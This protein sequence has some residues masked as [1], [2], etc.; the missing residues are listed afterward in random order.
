MLS[1]NHVPPLSLRSEIT[2]LV[3]TVVWLLVYQA[4]LRGLFLYTHYD[5][6][7]TI[8]SAVLLN[9]F[10]KGFRFDLI[11]TA[12]AVMPMVFTLLFQRRAAK[13]LQIRWWLTGIGCLITFLAVLELDFYKEFHQRLN[14]LVFE[15]MKEDPQTVLSMV[16]FGFPVIRYLLLIGALTFIFHK[17]VFYIDL[18]TQWHD[19]SPVNT[20]RIKVWAVRSLVF[21][22]VLGCTAASG[23]GTFRQGPPL[24]WGDAFFSEHTFANHL[25]L[26]GTFTLSK[27]ATSLANKKNDNRFW[28][29]RMTEAAATELLRKGWLT[30]HDQLIDADTAAL[31]RITSTPNA[32][33]NIKNVVIILMES[34]SGE[35][36]GA[37]GKEMGVTPAFDAL[38]H[39]GLI[40]ERF[41]SNG[42]H[43][44]QGMFATLACFPNLPGHE[45]L[46]YQPEGAHSFSGIAKL[47]SQRD[48]NQ[49]YV[50][51]G[52]FS[53]DNQ[54]GFFK[55]QGMTTF[56]G[57]E[58]Y[59]NPKFSD[60]T[61]GVSDEDMFDRA[62]VELDKLPKDQPFYAVLQTLSNHT[63]YGLP[64]PL[65]ME[66]VMVDGKFSER[67][68]AMRYS[69][70]ALG[71]FFEQAQ[72]ADY[73]KDTLFVILGDH[74]FGIDKQLT[75]LDLLR[76]H[77]PMLMIGPGIVE[78][79]GQRID[80]VTTQ[81]DIL[82][83]VM[84]LLGKPYQ[85]QCWG[86]DALNL[87]PGDNGL[88]V[89]KPSGN[90]PAVGIIADNLV[91]V[92]DPN[93]QIQLYEYQFL[94]ESSVR[95]HDD[96]TKKEA[97]WQLLQ[98]YIQT[99]LISLRENTTAP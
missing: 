37:L 4:G 17:V 43:T 6:T 28:F 18:R 50:Y 40:F 15:Y 70:Y 3:A 76:F 22:L 41:F 53:W 47:L 7:Q 88:V 80:T 57:R 9:A 74:G 85:H 64:E 83:T 34:F 63:P 90:D 97:L 87:P 11:I 36:V 51:N 21:L 81:V 99:A 79:Y 58:Q 93:E 5:L 31:R 52:S 10:G 65:P 84:S 23:R 16:W 38:A 91:L 75:A 61:W 39:Q 95:L 13:R 30:P 8:P 44:H 12:Y 27:A 24:R 62:L 33:P 72:Q 25:A 59:V 71:K 66:K 19:T 29:K 69:D 55:N 78:Q 54:E 98:A 82:P 14:S 48:F 67:L 35:F 86:R 49:T 56:I 68:T 77:V 32:T 26:N 73:Y 1:Q 42:T 94:P 2:F 60:P 89:I 46:M 96:A 92:R 45:Y 20:S